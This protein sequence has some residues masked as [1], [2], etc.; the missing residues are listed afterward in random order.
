MKCYYIITDL[1][2]NVDFMYWQYPHGDILGAVLGFADKQSTDYDNM[3]V[4]P[5]ASKK[6]WKEYY[7]NNSHRIA[8]IRA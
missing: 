5:C 4:Y 2:N 8:S 7:E 3:R 1:E 6:E